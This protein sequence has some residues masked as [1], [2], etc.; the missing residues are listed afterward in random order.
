[1]IARTAASDRWRVCA[2]L[3]LAATLGPVAAQNLAQ[4]PASTQRRAPGHGVLCRTDPVGAGTWLPTNGTQDVDGNA[5]GS[6]SVQLDVPSVAA[7]GTARAEIA[8]RE[9]LPVPAGSSP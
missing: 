2:G 4:N 6:G 1:M 5:P 7:A 3:C 9:C 8:A